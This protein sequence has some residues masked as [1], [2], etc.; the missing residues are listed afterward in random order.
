MTNVFPSPHRLH[1]TDSNPV[2]TPSGN[3]PLRTHALLHR[4]SRKVSETGTRCS[5]LVI[6][7][8][9]RNS[10][11]IHLLL[12][13]VGLASAIPGEHLPLVTA[14]VSVEYASTASAEGEQAGPS[15][16]TLFDDRRGSNVGDSVVSC[17]RGCF[18]I[19]LLCP[20][21]LRLSSRVHIAVGDNEVYLCHRCC[22]SSSSRYI[23]CC[24]SRFF[25]S[26]RSRL[27]TSTSNAVQPKRWLLQLFQ[28]QICSPSSRRPAV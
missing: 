6:C 15:A 18:L 27:R 17:K 13:A 21:S 12:W 1:V 19:L 10:G 11:N 22:S 3:A 20:W 14:H 2:Q 4:A 5:R 28:H 24:S 8:C 9:E 25:T 16:M 7:G 23:S 26:C